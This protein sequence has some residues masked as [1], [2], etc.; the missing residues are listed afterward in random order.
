M[1]YEPLK[2]YLLQLPKSKSEISLKFLEIESI[3]NA[4]LPKSASTYTEW[5][6]NQS[7]GSQGPSWLAAGFMVD[8]VNLNRGL[9]RFR[10]DPLARQDLAR[11]AKK[12]ESHITSV[13]RQ[14]A[15]VQEDL[16][17]D[18]G[19][20]RI[21]EWALAEG[22]IRLIGD[23]SNDPGVYAHIVDG[24]VYYIGSTKMGLKKRMYFYERPGKTQR[25]NLR[26]NPLIEQALK[27]GKKVWVIAASP[28][29]SEWNGL[30]VDFVVGLEAGLLAVI[31]PP[32]NMR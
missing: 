4:R 15:P 12:P 10:R 21:G 5:W 9:V 3:L 6:A 26:I 28:D 13:N 24:Q 22:G 8:G 32:W 29:T 20:L 1:K 16:L 2:I 30:P 17:K 18:A 14:A 11:K 31:S 19:F 27:A 23:I 7:H 25:T